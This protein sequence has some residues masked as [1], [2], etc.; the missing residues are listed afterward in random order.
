MYT[1][2]SPNGTP[3]IDCIKFRFLKLF[4]LKNGRSLWNNQKFV[5]WIYS[6]MVMVIDISPVNKI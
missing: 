2:P 6:L 5:R 3:K 1:P 4:W